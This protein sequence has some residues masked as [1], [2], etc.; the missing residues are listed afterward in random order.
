MGYIRLDR[1]IL[2]WEWYSDN[3]TKTIFIHCLLKANW[4]EAK[5]CGRVIERGSFVTSLPTLAHESG[6]S[7]RSVRTAL[8]HLKTT[9]ELTIKTTNKYSIITVSNYDYYQSDD[10]QTDCQTADNRQSTDSQST[11]IEK[12]KKK[13]K[14]KKDN[15]SISPNGRTDSP[16]ENAEYDYN[17]YSNVENA[18]HILNHLDYK[19]KEWLLNNKDV[20]GCIKKWLEYKD[21]RKPY[22][23]NHYSG[24]TS[25][26]TLFNKFVNTAKKYGV[27]ALFDVVD[28]S[29]V[30]T[31][32]GIIWDRLERHKPL[33]PSE[34]S[35]SKTIPIQSPKEDEEDKEWDDL[36][37]DEWVEKMK[38]L[39]KEG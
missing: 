35:I 1:K 26:V 27:D 6:L 25:L 16:E 28:T 18:L 5:F 30:N 3:N 39:D 9:G 19:E 2:D 36:T 32:Q 13:K 17:K 34:S 14:N 12:E 8:E 11:S 22:K 21:S 24:Y 10:N 23:D 31:Y 38:A 33:E 37:D 20:W 29:I 15:S 4:K 7:V